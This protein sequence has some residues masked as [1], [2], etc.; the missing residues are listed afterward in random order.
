VS[1]QEAREI[2]VDEQRKRF[3]RRTLL[4]FGVPTAAALA[5]G[6]VVAV[7]AIPGSDAKITACYAGPGGATVDDHFEPVGAMRIIDAATPSDPVLAQSSQYSCQD[8]ETQITWNQNG[9]EGPTGPPGAA[10]GQGPA[11][12]RGPQGSPLVGVTSFGLDTSS[13]RIFLK[14]DGI[15]GESTD[16]KHKGEILVETAAIG[17]NP[18]TAVPNSGTGAGAGKVSF[19]T[20]SI[21]RK[22]DKASAKLFTAAASGKHFANAVVSFAKPSSKGATDFI[23][24]KL[25]DLTITRV[26]DGASGKGVPTEEVDFK[27]AKLAET[28]FDAKGKPTTVSYNLKA[29]KTA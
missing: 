7:G 28:V 18:T 26:L 15:M 4:T 25:S 3:G 6:A 10:G 1:R 8:G 23:V 14:L 27:F 13:S 2:V 21:T 11:G 12:A 29:T 9:P 20:F 16:D 5:A 19:S 17:V 24:Y 22:I